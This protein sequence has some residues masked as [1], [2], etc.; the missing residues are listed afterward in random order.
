M[1]TVPLLPN[2]KIHPF[3]LLFRVFVIMVSMNVLYSSFTF[4]VS[5]VALEYSIL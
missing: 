1:P 4:P 3:L 5:S 2:N